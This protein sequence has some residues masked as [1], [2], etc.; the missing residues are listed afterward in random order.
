VARDQAE[1]EDE[2]GEAFVIAGLSSQADRGHWHARRAPSVLDRLGRVT[3]AIAMDA[4]G[5]MSLAEP[6]IA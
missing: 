5:F 6:L 2:G 3:S 4:S 1:T